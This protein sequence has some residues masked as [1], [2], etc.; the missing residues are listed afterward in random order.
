[1]SMPIEVMADVLSEVYSTIYHFKCMPVE[2]V[3]SRSLQVFMM[4]GLDDLALLWMELHL[5]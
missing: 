3:F 5:P 2:L 4:T 1:M